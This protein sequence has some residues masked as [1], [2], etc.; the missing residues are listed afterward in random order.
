MKTTISLLL[1][2]AA[3]LLCASA[4]DATS[5]SQGRI[6]ITDLGPADYGVAG[7]MRLNPITHTAGIAHFDRA[8]KKLLYTTYTTNGWTTLTVDSGRF[9]PSLK[10]GLSGQPAISY[11]HFTSGS[12]KYIECKYDGNWA[13]QTL[14][15][16]IDRTADI[17]PFSSLKFSQEGRPKIG[18]YDLRTK[19]SNSPS[20]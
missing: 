9:N 13:I 12:L 1:A 7:S 10:H 16:L 3:L 19:N 4:Q 18:S 8:H 5:F 2:A 11:Y 15:N 20:V 14:D 6:P 17:G